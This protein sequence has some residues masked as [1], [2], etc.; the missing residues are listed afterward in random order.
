MNT[1]NMININDIQE[2]GVAIYLGMMVK[3]NEMRQIFKRNFNS[4]E[5]ISAI[6]L[7][8]L[9][10]MG[11]L[12][13]TLLKNSPDLPVVLRNLGST[14]NKFGVDVRHFAPMLDSLHESFSYYFPNVYGIKVCA[15]SDQC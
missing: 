2:I 3:D 7:K 11:W 8:F 15:M 10:M 13:R 5:K 12:I 6:S 9:N 14:H 4:K 1:L